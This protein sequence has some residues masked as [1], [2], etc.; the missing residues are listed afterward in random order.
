MYVLMMKRNH[1]GLIVYSRHYNKFSFQICLIF[2]LLYNRVFKN[3]NLKKPKLAY[4]QSI[5]YKEK[6]FFSFNYLE[7]TITYIESC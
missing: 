3:Y 5:S 1:L 6:L 4:T 7:T 2:F